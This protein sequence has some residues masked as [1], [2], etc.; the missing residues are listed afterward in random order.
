MAS[1]YPLGLLGNLKNVL[2]V[3]RPIMGTPGINPAAPAAGMLDPK[4]LGLLS[5]AF[6]LLQA[7]GRREGPRIGFG[8]GIGMA[9]MQGLGA[10]QQAQQMQALSE[11]RSA[12]T[13][14]ARAKA[15]RE[16]K[17]DE[18]TEKGYAA[19]ASLL[20]G[21][22]LPP[23]LQYAPE[24]LLNSE[25]TRKNAPPSRP[26]SVPQGDQKAVY[27]DVRN[28]DGTWGKELLGKG[29]AF[30]RPDSI[31]FDNKDRFKNLSTLADDYTTSAAP[32]LEM[33]QGI[34]R[35]R[36][37]ASNPDPLAAKQLQAALN[38][39][40][41]TGVKAKAEL[42]KYGNYGDLS[43]R[44]V[45]M[46]SQFVAGTPTK[47][48]TK[49]ALDLADTLESQFLRPSVEALNTGVRRRAELGEVDPSMVYESVPWLP[50]G[51]SQPKNGGLSA[52]EQAEL[53]ALRKRFGR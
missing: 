43:Q 8:Q 17:K 50:W 52:D 35:V 27:R 44:F 48:Q 18:R 33:Q 51:A 31:T 15:E 40:A 5:T 11:Y 29:D 24:S 12:Q 6:G 37:L 16:T 1:N 20:E 38:N 47:E 7:G 36:A 9:G 3:D 32:L 19:A 41:K 21:Q 49:M 23:E 13:A 28:P 46:A 34:A 39:L 45:G 26:Y 2:G 4:T 14:A 30:R 22:G 42:D 53:D 25:L 10:Y